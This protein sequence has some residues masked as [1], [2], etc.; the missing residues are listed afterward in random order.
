MAKVVQPNGMRQGASPKVRCLCCALT[1]SQQVHHD[2]QWSVTNEINIQ[3]TVRNVTD[4]VSAYKMQ[5]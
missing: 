2:Q 1:V 5:H 3:L 4:Y